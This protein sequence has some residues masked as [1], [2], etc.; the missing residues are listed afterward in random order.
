M[1]REHNKYRFYKDD[2]ENWY[3]DL[4]QYLEVGGEA[5][6]LQMVLGADDLLEHLTENGDEV[7]LELGTDKKGEYYWDYLEKC[8]NNP[9]KI[10]AAY[11]YST[12][13]DIYAV[14]LCPV[15]EFIFGDFPNVIYF[16]KI[17]TSIIKY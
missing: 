17:D 7:T 9:T 8:I 2:N 6:D 14:W 5:V 13:V 10:G 4:P 12:G 15:V 3:I 1:I 11:M 16:R